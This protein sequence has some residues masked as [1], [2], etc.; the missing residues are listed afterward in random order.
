VLW[1]LNISLTAVLLD[2]WDP[3]FLSVL[4]V[5]LATITFV[6]VVA[7]IDA[8]LPITQVVKPIR[9]LY[10]SAFFAAFIL[11]YNLG[12][13]FSDPVTAAAVMAGTPVYAALTLAVVAHRA[14][15]PGFYVAATLTV[16]GSLI[17]LTS[18][19]ESAGEGGTNAG[20]LLILTSYIFWNLF[21]LGVQQGFVKKT[22][23][24]QRTLVIFVGATLWLILGWLVLR[25][26]ELAPPPNLNPNS[27]EIALLIV[28][29]VLI[30]AGGVLFWNLGVVRLGLAIGSIWQNMVPVFGVFIAAL[31]GFV[32]TIGQILGGLIVL[33][34]V[35]WMQ[36]QRRDT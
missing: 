4:R 15:D 27:K 34:G 1:G 23:Q 13:H 26:F 19:W 29:A 30:T 11:L 5:A 36:R 31:L 24:L 7:C 35:L 32:P 22:T 2:T 3:Y 9:V 25:W 28:C 6:I 17:A 10:T 14:L 21:T 18:R 33:S 8:K 12:L 20:A 16:I